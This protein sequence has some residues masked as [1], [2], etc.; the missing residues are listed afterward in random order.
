MGSIMTYPGPLNS[1]L[2]QHASPEPSHSGNMPGYRTTHANARRHISAYLD[3]FD[4]TVND[5]STD[6]DKG[7]EGVARVQDRG[8]VVGV[9][10]SPAAELE[11]ALVRPAS[12]RYLTVVGAV[13]LVGVQSR[14]TYCSGGHS[15]SL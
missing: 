9:Q 14:Y 4:L 13:K 1:A 11:V 7:K 2:L 12:A 5:Y 15:L 6:P 8:G 3:Y 10:Q